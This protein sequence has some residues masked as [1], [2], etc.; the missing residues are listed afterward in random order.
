M[1]AKARH[2]QTM[3]EWLGDPEN[4]IPTRKDL[5]LICGICKETMYLHFTPDELTEI[6][7]EGLAMRRRK[8]APRLASIDL[9][10][11]K[12]AE[13]GDPKAIK[14]AYQ[15]FEDWGEKKAVDHSSS[16]GSMSPKETRITA[17]DPVEAAKEYQRIIKGDG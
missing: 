13:G 16:D 10:L 17:V 15:R 9:A 6:E 1:E 7:D 4:P 8:Y 14:L 3:L 5:A 12:Q 11:I 2:R